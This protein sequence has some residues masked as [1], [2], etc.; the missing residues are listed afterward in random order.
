M[1]RAVKCAGQVPSVIGLANLLHDALGRTDG[2]LIVATFQPV[3]P[4]WKPRG[5]LENHLSPMTRP[6]PVPKGTTHFLALNLSV[7]V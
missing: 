1:L 2:T 6:Y 3:V 4:W 5:N 7:I